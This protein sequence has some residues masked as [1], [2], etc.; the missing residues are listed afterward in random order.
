MEGCRD[1]WRMTGAGGGSGKWGEV[2]IN[3]QATPT[4]HCLWGV[5]TCMYVTESGVWGWQ[6]VFLCSVFFSFFYY[7]T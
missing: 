3:Q 7:I 6:V 4:V 5:E 1:G 2:E